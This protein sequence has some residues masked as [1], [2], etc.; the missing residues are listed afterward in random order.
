MKFTNL[1]RALSGHELLERTYKQTGRVH[2][3]T[4]DMFENSFGCIMGKI[5]ECDLT[6]IKKDKEINREIIEIRRRLF[7]Y[8]S[9]SRNPNFSA[10]LSLTSII[11][12]YERIGD[13]TKN[14]AQL[15]SV[16]SGRPET[17]S[18]NDRLMDMY[19]LLIEIFTL[20]KRAFENEDEEK[21]KVAV[22]THE[23]V[24]KMHLEILQSIDRDENIGRQE[25][26]IYALLLNFLRRINGHLS[27]ICTATYRSFPKIGF[28]DEPEV[29]E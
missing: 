9:T 24:K 20:T 7:N 1:F 14:I 19:D 12:D 5:P 4:R 13:Y 25:A 2:D 17:E 23:K 18:Y 29:L 16:L 11:I 27:N 10:A 15:L 8:V 21:A 6:V 3:K 22:Q 26:L 28:A